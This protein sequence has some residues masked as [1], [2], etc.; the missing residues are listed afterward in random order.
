MA[1]V[2][3]F[4]TRPSAYYSVT[5]CCLFTSLFIFVSGSF[6]SSYVNAGVARK[7]VFS[8]FVLPRFYVFIC[9]CVSLTALRYLSGLRRFPRVLHEGG[10]TRSPC[11]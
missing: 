11:R 4:F 3:R 10:L 1:A 8:V 6:S 7:V 9:L 5:E 2:R